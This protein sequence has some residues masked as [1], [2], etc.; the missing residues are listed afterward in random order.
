MNNIRHLSNLFSESLPGHTNIRAG[1]SRAQTSKQESSEEILDDK[2]LMSVT[3]MDSN[4]LCSNSNSIHS[5]SYKIEGTI[6]GDEMRGVF[7]FRDNP[8]QG[9]VLRRTNNSLP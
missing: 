8:K 7:I 1:N 4:E 5:F 6:Q 3:D 2:V 9:F